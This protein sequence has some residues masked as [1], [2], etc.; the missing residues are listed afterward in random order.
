MAGRAKRNAARMERRK[1]KANRK[2]ANAA[3]YSSRVGTDSNKKKKGIGGKQAKQ[4]L[5]RCSGGC[6]NIGCTRCSQIAR[7]G[8]HKLLARIVGPQKADRMCEARGW[9]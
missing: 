9:L 3:K 4:M 8:A 5:A 7:V 1:Q 2:A 6:G